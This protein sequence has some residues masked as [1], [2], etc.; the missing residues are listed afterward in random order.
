MPEPK[1]VA[2]T[3]EDAFRL[4][5]GEAA[6]AQPHFV[7]QCRVPLARPIGRAELLERLRLMARHTRRDPA[8]HIVESGR[9]RPVAIAHHDEDVLG[10]GTRPTQLLLI[11]GPLD[12]ELWEGKEP[13]RPEY[14]TVDLVTGRID[15]AV[16]L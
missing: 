15:H 12:G 5:S 14:Y 10:Q 13:E 7:M 1:I 11:H 3:L 6:A 9:L 8:L 4:A 2:T 16:L